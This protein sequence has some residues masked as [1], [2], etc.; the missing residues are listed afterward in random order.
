MLLPVS[1]VNQ[2]DIMQCKSPVL[3]KKRLVAVHFLKRP[4]LLG[5]HENHK[6]YRLLF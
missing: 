1:A 5:D 2:V 4:K 3:K 6:L